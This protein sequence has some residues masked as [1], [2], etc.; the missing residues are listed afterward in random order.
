MDKKPTIKTIAKIAGVSHVTVSRALRGYPDIS[1]ATTEKIRAIAKEIGYTPNAFAR[2]LSSKRSN[3]IGMIVPAMGADT[4]YNEVFNTVSAESAKHG[5]SVLLGS[6][7]RSIELEKSFCH[8]MCENRVGALLIASVSSDVSHIKEICKGIVPIIFIGGKTGMEEEYCIAAD[9]RHSGVLAV[10]HLANLGHKDI[11][12]F[13]YH[14]KSRTILQKIEGYEETMKSLG[15]SPQVYIE[16][17]HADTFTAG[18]TLT[19]RLIA[20]KKLPTA[21]WCASDL[22]AMGVLDSL[23]SHKVEV[24]RD[25]AVMGHDDLFLG[26]M[27]FISLTTL[28][29]PKEAI[30]KRAIN[31]ALSIMGEIEEEQS[32]KTLLKTELIVRD[33]TAGK[34][35]L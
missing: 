3:S 22:M 28:T 5:L 8:I 9:Y 26:R 15:L 21:I 20:Q 2:S 10:Q 33:S 11:A 16:G 7:G 34:S 29:L 4:L 6:C 30:G 19:D 13:A 18:K 23:K 31:L 14:P 27:S 1:V 25:V 35:T 24:P 32:H 17:D 12:L